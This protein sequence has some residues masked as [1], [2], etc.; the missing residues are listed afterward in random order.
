MLKGDGPRWLYAFAML[1]ITVGWAAYV[2]QVV[3][4]TI[5]EPDIA[6][7][8]QLAGVSAVQGALNTLLTLTVQF[9]FRKAPPRTP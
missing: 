2:L 6:N 3:R 5:K 8:L 1:F 9:F 4:W 7:I